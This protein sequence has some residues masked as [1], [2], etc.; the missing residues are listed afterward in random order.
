LQAGA[1]RAFDVE[2]NP[3]APGDFGGPIIENAGGDMMCKKL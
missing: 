2:N 1:R 3:R